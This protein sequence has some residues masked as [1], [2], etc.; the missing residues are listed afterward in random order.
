MIGA[1][2]AL[3]FVDGGSGAGG[4]QLLLERGFVVSQCVTGAQLAGQL[5]DGLSHD[6]TVHKGP[7]GLKAAVEKEGADDGLDRIGEDGAFAAKA[8]AIF[9]TAEAQVITEPDGRS[10]LGHMLTADQLGTD[11]GQFAFMPFG[12]EEEEGFADHKAQHGIPEKLEALV[13]SLG[14]AIISVFNGALVGE[15]A[16][17]EG[18]HEQ[19]G[20]GKAMPDCSLQ[21]RQNRFHVSLDGFEL[22]NRFEG[23]RAKNDVELRA[24]PMFL[25][26]GTEGPGEALHHIIAVLVF[27]AGYRQRGLGLR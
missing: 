13:V 27:P 1:A 4:L 18:A 25:L 5:L 11:A 15:G 8:A 2:L 21:I 17:R 19:F 20:S 16:V 6:K 23:R 14:A 3:D 7:S 24:C 26:D 22:L 10:N 9:A 12:M